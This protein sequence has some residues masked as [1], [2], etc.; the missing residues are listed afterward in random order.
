MKR[1]ITHPNFKFPGSPRVS[2]TLVRTK[3]RSTNN[4]VTKCQPTKALQWHATYSKKTMESVIEA[5]ILTEP[6]EGEAL[7]I[8]RILSNLIK[9][10]ELQSEYLIKIE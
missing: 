10:K 2:T 4:I 6:F 7:L 8:P 9:L 1:L 5:T 3:N